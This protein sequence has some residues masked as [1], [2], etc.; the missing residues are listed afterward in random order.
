VTRI[1]SPVLLVLLLCALV[2]PVGAQLL[3]VEGGTITQPDEGEREVLGYLRYG[4][5]LW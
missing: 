5:A 4:V 1:L 3:L 2:I